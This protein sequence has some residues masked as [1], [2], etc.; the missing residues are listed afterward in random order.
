MAHH[1]LR[2]V[3]SHFLQLMVDAITAIKEMEVGEKERKKERKK[4]DFLRAAADSGEGVLLRQLRMCGR[5]NR[6]HK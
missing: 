4:E 1:W 5:V 2:D 3:L 6:C